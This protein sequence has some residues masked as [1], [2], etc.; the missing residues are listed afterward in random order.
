M[1]KQLR[2]TCIEVSYKDS[3]NESFNEIRKRKDFTNSLANKPLSSVKN[4]HV[5]YE[6]HLMIKQDDSLNRWKVM[7]DDEFFFSF[8]CNNEKDFIILFEEKLKKEL[9]ERNYPLDREAGIMY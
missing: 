6:L 2:L 8:T 9:C 5:G 3:T 1:E 7:N 4:I